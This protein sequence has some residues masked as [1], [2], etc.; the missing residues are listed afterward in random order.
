MRNPKVPGKSSTKD[1]DDILYNDIKRTMNKSNKKGER[2][3]VYGEVMSKVYSPRKSFKGLPDRVTSRSRSGVSVFFG[4]AKDSRASLGIV[5]MTGLRI[6]AATVLTI[7]R[8]LG[9]IR[10]I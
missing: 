7:W 5:K 6:L 9:I 4:V 10:K 2:L 1:S 3:N 8:F